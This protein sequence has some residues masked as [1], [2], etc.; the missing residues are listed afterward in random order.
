MSEKPD[1]NSQ[2]N[3]LAEELHEQ[4]KATGK[5]STPITYQTHE[6]F[7]GFKTPSKKVELCADYLELMGISPL[8]IFREPDE[9]PVSSPEILEQFP[10]VLSTGSRNLVYY[11][12]SHRNIPSL[13][14]KSPDPQLEIHPE[15]AAELDIED[16]EW[17]Y[18]CSPR[19]R[20]EIKA[21]YYTG[22]DPKVVHAPHGYWY[23]VENGWQRVNIN[24]LTDDQKL[25][26]VTGSVPIKALLCRVEK[27][28][29]H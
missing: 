11:H 20:I 17:V 9:G 2:K 8:P 18:L 5:Y 3:L 16:G 28:D 12:S 10:L 23:G 24:M 6:K 26:P 27:I 7:G 15:T 29:R 19:G 1:N 22:T 13:Y 25:C 21:K 4:L 14:K